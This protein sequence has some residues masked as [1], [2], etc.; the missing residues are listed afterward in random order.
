MDAAV[1]IPEAR[2]DVEKLPKWAQQHIRV[3]QM[4]LREARE[5]LAEGPADSNVI[6]DPYGEPPVPLAKDT[7]IRFILSP[8][9]ARSDHIT[10]RHDG[11]GLQIMGG[12]RIGVHPRSSNV[13]NIA[14]R[15]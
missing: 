3:L 11:D 5:R 6:A 15:S 12:D 9:N 8:T 13:V 10:V 4:S 7:A 14:V 2:G 1:K